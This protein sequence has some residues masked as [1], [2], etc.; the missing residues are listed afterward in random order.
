M[1]ILFRLALLI[2]GSLVITGQVFCEDPSPS[3]S[4]EGMASTVVNAVA[5]NTDAGVPDSITPPGTA[6]TNSAWGAPVT[7]NAGQQV[8]FGLFRQDAPT[9]MFRIERFEKEYNFKPHSI[10][11]Y[12][13]WE[14]PFPM[15]DCMRVISYGAVPHIVWEPWYWGD[16]NAV[17]LK[18]I[19]NGK[20]DGFITKWAQGVKEFGYPIFI[21][22]AHEFNIDGYPWG[23]IHQN[24]D[25]TLYIKAFQRVVQIYRKVGAT[26]AMFVWCPMNFSYPDEPWN[27]YIKSYPGD[28]YVDW[29][30]IDGYNWGKAREWSF[31]QT[32]EELFREPVRIISRAFPT[33]P[34]MV[35]EFSSDPTGGDKAKW[36]S[37]I[38]DYLQATLK[39]VKAIYWFDLKKEA[40][41]R[42]NSTP[43]TEKAFRQMLTSPIFKANPAQMANVT[44]N[45]VVRQE[46]REINFA[47][48]PTPKRIDGSARD[49]SRNGFTL[50]DGIKSVSS[51]TPNWKGS[52]DLSA[53]AQFSWDASYLY[54]LLYIKDDKPFKN[55][56]KKAGM[57]NGDAVEIAISTDPDAGPNR[58]A[59]EDQDFQLVLSPGNKNLKPSIWIFKTSTLLDPSYIAA[60]SVKGGYV[61]EAKIPWKELGNYTPKAGDE[62]GFTFS[63]DDSDDSNIRETQILFTGDYLFYKDPSVWGRA[64]LVK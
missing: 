10:M 58:L 52:S 11:W 38:P 19:V 40:D 23:T 21:R 63:I 35:A 45:Y 5:I 42:A 57:W 47:Y 6:T 24:Q 9:K 4:A 34:I 20:W 37:D 43:E 33:K 30:G 12:L 22:Y 26:N 25:A 17:S 29:I 44:V 27:D 56:K 60:E 46:R 61:I 53:K 55:D 13:D 2:V 36:I 3:L 49:W 8:Y 14:Q 28:E 41:W 32:F 39:N 48:T 50:V 59:Y 31:W 15:E 62:L 64:K 54:A 7:V 51:G 1:K 16:E 18:D